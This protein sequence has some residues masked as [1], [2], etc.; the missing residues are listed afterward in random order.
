MTHGQR[1]GTGAGRRD[2]DDRL[3]SPALGRDLVA[4]AL[5]GGGS[6]GY[7]T[8]PGGA[9]TVRDLRHGHRCGRRDA[10]LAAGYVFNPVSITV[11]VAGASVGGEEFP[12]TAATATHVGVIGERRVGGRL[13]Q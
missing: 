7:A 13:R 3:V 8:A 11:A 10:E 9:P 6:G 2:P 12:A 4:V 5:V 1:A